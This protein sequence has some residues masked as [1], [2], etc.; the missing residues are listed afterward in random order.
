MLLV[1]LKRCLAQTVDE[2]LLVCTV[3]DQTKIYYLYYLVKAWSSNFLTIGQQFC[4]ISVSGFVIDSVI[5]EHGCQNDSFQMLDSFLVEF[6]IQ[7]WAFVSSS[8]NFRSLATLV[9]QML[10]VDFLSQMLEIGF[11]SQMSIV[12]L[13]R[14]ISVV[15]FLSQISVWPRKPNIG[16][17]LSQPNVGYCLS[18]PNVN[19]LVRQSNVDSWIRKTN[20]CSWLSQPNISMAE[21]VKC[22]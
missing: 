12:D 6:L 11:H 15:G 18:Q 13:G 5:L 10:V 1:C 3:F 21:E 7:M 17:W 16:S 4:S 14:Q 20:I 2:R 9:S 8:A 19:S 22:R